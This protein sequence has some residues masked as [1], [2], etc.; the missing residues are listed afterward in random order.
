MANRDCQAHIG[1]G[2]LFLPKSTLFVYPAMICVENERGKILAPETPE[3]PP[4]HAPFGHRFHGAN[5]SQS[6]SRTRR[7]F[8]ALGRPDSTR[9]SPS[10]TRFNPARSTLRPGVR[11]QNRLAPPSCSPTWPNQ[12]RPSCPLRVNRLDRNL[13]AGWRN[14]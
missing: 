6:A 13:S 7:H 4:S 10:L 1:V 9:S 8:S 2:N 11:C 5:S 12:S 14:E 3:I